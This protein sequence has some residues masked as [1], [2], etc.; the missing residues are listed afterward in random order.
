MNQDYKPNSAKHRVVFA[1]LAL[2]A[3]TTTIALAV[4]A[5]L[6]THGGLV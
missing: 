2:V 6:A 5:P 1:T 4:L 3:S